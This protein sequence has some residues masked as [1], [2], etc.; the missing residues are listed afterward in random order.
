MLY[1]R[2]R[3][4][5]SIFCLYLCLLFVTRNNFFSM[6]NRLFNLL[7]LLA[8][9]SGAL[10]SC[11]SPEAY[12][13]HKGSFTSV[14]DVKNSKITPLFF[15]EDSFVVKNLSAMGLAEGDRAYMNVKY[16]YDVYTMFAPDM[17]ITQVYSKVPFLSIKKNSEI[18]KT[19]YNSLLNGVY[20][21][22]FA[23]MGSE[24]DVRY[25]WADDNTQNIVVRYDNDQVGQFEMAL[26]SISGQALC[27][28]L[29]SR[30]DDK[31]WEEDGI[32]FDVNAKEVARVLTFKVDW[33]K[34]KE[35]I[36]VADREKLSSYEKLTS[37]IAIT[38]EGCK[39]NEQGLYVPEGVVYTQ[40][41]IK[42][43]WYNN[44]E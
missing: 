34:L 33:G 32:V 10:V 13:T 5:F 21:V 16:V 31:K 24:V 27:F 1:L 19:R 23:T 44:A 37:S 39:K 25:L 35:E 36:S 15:E 4:Y 28:R 43:P 29:Y 30:L 41:Y 22:D 9:L 12:L 26:D 18:D 14:F 3:V 11:D 8:F 7:L 2:V 20:P 42:N 17:E 38:R 6:K 40:N